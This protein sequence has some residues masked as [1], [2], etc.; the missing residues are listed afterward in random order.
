MY[1]NKIYCFGDGYSHG[2]IWPE[3]PQLLEALLPD[4]EI[5]VIS[6][7]GAGPEYLVTQFSKILPIDGTVIF[8]WPMANR[9]DKVIQD[10]Y[11][12][13]ILESDPI[14]HFNTYKHDQDIWWL[15]SASKLKDI[16]EYHSKFIQ[17]TQAEIRLN[18][19]KTLVKEILDKSGHSYVF[20]STSE[21]EEFSRT[22]LDIRG[23]EIQP[24]PLSHFYFL[25]E[26]IMPALK[27]T[28]CNTKALET[29]LIARKW[30]PYDPDRAE[31]WQNIKT[32]LKNNNNK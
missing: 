11:W 7:I 20:T 2:H 23:N 18:V 19:Y 24:E 30:K 16:N 32:Q 27:L 21:Q 6:G 9:F 10:K 22:Y 17:S 25:I 15:S 5:K 31:I 29:L 26:K 28:S 3:W 4:Y 12:N 1:T 13:E 14:Y 8:Q